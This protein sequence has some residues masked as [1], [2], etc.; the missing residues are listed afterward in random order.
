MWIAFV[1]TY[2]IGPVAA[3]LPERWRKVLPMAG[4]VQWERATAVSGIWE[5][6]AAVTGLA[7]WYLYLVGSVVSAGM[8]LA[9]NG[10]LGPGVTE[11]QVGGAAF[12]LFLAQPLTWVIV[13]FL[14]EGVVRSSG[15]LF[16]DS[17]LGTVPLY[18]LERIVFFVRNPRTAISPAAV[19]RNVESF[20]DSLRERFLTAR[21]QEMPDELRR[22]GNS[23][24]EMLEISAS[25]RKMDWVAPKIVLVDA[26]YYRLEEVSLKTGIRPFRYRLKRLEAGRLG[27][28]VIVYKSADAVVAKE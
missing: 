20:A 13:C 4:F 26:A 22:A 14:V 24:S 11:Q 3:L 27:R 8:D 25:R 6:G 10:K 5:I 15:A 7:F 18:L 17:A 23:S 21:S 2:V 28:T 1:C 19:R 12:F 16:T 9:V